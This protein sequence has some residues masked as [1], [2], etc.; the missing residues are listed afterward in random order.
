L[1]ANGNIIYENDEV[2]LKSSENKFKITDAP[3]LAKGETIVAAVTGYNF[4]VMVGCLIVADI[5]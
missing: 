1:T 3:P 2:L 5:K 4:R